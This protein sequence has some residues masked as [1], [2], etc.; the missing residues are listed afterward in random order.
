MLMLQNSILFACKIIYIYILF[1]MSENQPKQELALETDEQARN[2]LQGAPV[3]PPTV[4]DN[5]RAAQASGD[6]AALEAA[7]KVADE[8]YMVP[9]SKPSDE[10]TELHDGHVQASLLA[11]EIK[12]SNEESVKIVEGNEGYLRQRENVIRDLSSSID[13]NNL[14]ETFRAIIKLQ[15]IDQL[16]EDA[17]SIILS[18]KAVTEEQKKTADRIKTFIGRK[19]LFQAASSGRN[20]DGYTSEMF[21]SAEKTFK[22]RVNSS[23]PEDRPYLDKQ[24]EVQQMLGEWKSQ[25]TA[26]RQEAQAILGFSD[27]DMYHM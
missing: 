13:P 6:S 24:T 8:A 25:K 22:Q 7:T 3:A 11:G 9:S 12:K 23:S 2:R 26:A 20:P 10:T 19:D 1:S 16:D 4:M 5:L 27:D 14:K 15:N 21:N 18:R 17:I